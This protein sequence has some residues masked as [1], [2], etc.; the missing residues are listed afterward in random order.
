MLATTTLFALLAPGA[1]AQ[2]P[3]G[4]AVEAAVRRSPAAAEAGFRVREAGAA[5]DEARLRRLPSL[6][7]GSS[8]AR[9]DGPVYAFGTLLDQRSFTQADFDASRLNRPGYLSG[10]RNSLAAS[11]PIFAGFDLQSARRTGRLGVE[12]AEAGRDLSLQGARFAALEPFLEILLRGRLVASLDERI[13]ASESEI[14]SARRLKEKGLALGSDYFAALAA[15]GRLKAWRSRE[16][17]ARE[18]A[19]S[20][21]AALMGVDAASLEVRGFLSPKDAPLPGEAEIVEEA[22]RRRPELRQGALGE[23]MASEAEERERRSLLPRVEAFGALE[24]DTRDFNSNPWSKAFGVRA[25]IPLGDATYLSRRARA[26]AALEAS[27]ARTLQAREG[28]RIEVS[29]TYRALKGERESLPIAQ[30]TVEQ[31]RRS[32]ELFRPLYREGRASILDLL[33][34]EEGLAAAEAALL[35]NIHALRSGRARLMLASGGLD[36]GAIG[37]MERALEEK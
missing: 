1:W 4:E 36:A 29:R 9:G 5:L 15:L 6:S 37:E 18:G 28:V 12:A 16:A 17:S 34:A 3:L 25:S 11:V 33:R 13:A 24:T 32:L 31:A 35:G 19:R 20:A 14:E 10:F 30:D 8:F 26:R 2:V 21:L 7:V 23:G 27:R 22:L